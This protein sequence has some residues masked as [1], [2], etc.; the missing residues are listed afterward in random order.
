MLV[1]DGCSN[2]DNNNNNDTPPRVAGLTYRW[3]SV[4][5]QFFTLVGELAGEARCQPELVLS[6]TR[7]II[8][9]V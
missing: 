2:R 1:R 5:S 6:D 3:G 7:S 8:T 4:A 9:S